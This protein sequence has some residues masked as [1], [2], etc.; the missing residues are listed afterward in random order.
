MN[1]YTPIICAGTGF[2]GGNFHCPAPSR[3][4]AFRML[5]RRIAVGTVRWTPHEH[6]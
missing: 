4:D 3:K 1:F 2:W 6:R 5:E